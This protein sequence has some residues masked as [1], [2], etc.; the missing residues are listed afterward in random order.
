MACY[1]FSA[2]PLPEQMHENWAHF[3]SLP[4][5]K[6]RLCSANHRPGY[7]SNLP[8]D[9]PSTAWAY[10]EE[11][12]K[13]G[14]GWQ[15]PSPISTIGSTQYDPP[16]AQHSAEVKHLVAKCRTL[17]YW[18]LGARR[19]TAGCTYSSWGSNRHKQNKLNEISYEPTDNTNINKL[20]LLNYP[21][22]EHCSSI[23]ATLMYNIYRT[24]HSV[25]TLSAWQYSLQFL[26]WL[27]HTLAW[28]SSSGDRKTYYP[29]LASTHVTHVAMTTTY[30]PNSP[31]FIYKT[32]LQKMCYEK[33]FQV[34]YR[35]YNVCVTAIQTIGICIC[36]S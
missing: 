10:C 4:P 6:L 26:G 33:P 32:F 29:W 34:I 15:E 25:H 22:A 7:W 27:Q 12:Q 2:K 35:T 14:P 1:P 17:A 18:H 36:F 23:C 31:V 13:T 19:C 3:L 5:N 21:I 24:S 28:L 9:W 8:C 16:P 11:R 20:E 30:T